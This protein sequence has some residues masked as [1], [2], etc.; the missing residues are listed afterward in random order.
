MSLSI[1][2]IAKL[3]R[4]DT[5]L[6]RR[7]WNTIGALDDPDMRPPG[8][9][10]A[11]EGARC[12]ALARYVRAR[13]IQ[14]YFGLVGLVAFPTSMVVKYGATWWDLALVNIHLLLTSSGLLHG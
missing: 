4:V 14:F 9:F 7:A 10:R 2:L 3:S 11:G 6:A 12:Y 13:P 8:D 1:T 5:E